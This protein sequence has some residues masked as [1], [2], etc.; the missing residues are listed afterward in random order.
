MKGYPLTSRDYALLLAV[1]I[2]G[3]IFT[4]AGSIFIPEQVRPFTYLLAVL[5]LLFAFFFRVKPAEPV[6]LGKFPAII[7]G[8]IGAVI[9]MIED[10][11]IRHNYSSKVLIVLAGAVLI[12][13]VAGY[14][15]RML[16]K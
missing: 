4:E 14:L 5:L 10:F 9:I 2:G 13:L 7:L 3:Y 16:A 1:F 8:A 6:E 12:P 15:Y 11:L